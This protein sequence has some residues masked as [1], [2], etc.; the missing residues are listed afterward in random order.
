MEHLEKILKKVKNEIRGFKVK[1]ELADNFINDHSE[2][3]CLKIAK[4]L[5]ESS[6]YQI[7]AFAVFILGNIA[8]KSSDALFYLKNTISKDE[9]WRVQEILAK[10]FDTMCSNRGY[11]K[12]LPI[13]GEWLRNENPNV[14]RAVTEGLRIWTSREYFKTNPVKAIKFL[15]NLKN[16]KSEYVRKSVGNA[17]RDISRKHKE[18]IKKE[19]ERWEISNKE[20]KQVYNLAMKFIN[21]ERQNK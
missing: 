19:L 2:L 10:A 7:R 9:N 13:I 4:E 17:L 8:H 15:S 16:D 11:E 1:E 6:E 12:S 20:I 21:K 3:E 14:R 18:L 5:F